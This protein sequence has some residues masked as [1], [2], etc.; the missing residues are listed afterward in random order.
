MTVS[1]A[2]VEQAPSP[3]A[4]IGRLARQIVDAICQ[5][6]AIPRKEQTRQLALLEQALSMMQDA[7]QRIATLEDHI[8]H[9]E[10]LSRTDFLTGI[11]NR[12]GFHDRL[13]S[14]LSGADRHGDTGVVV[15]IDLDHF[16][17]INDRH[18]HEAGDAVLRQVA[19]TLRGNV[20]AGD[21]VARLGGDEFAVVLTH[22][23][24]AEGMYRA[25]RLLA[26]L[27]QAT[28]DYGNH[29]FRIEAS[30][31]AANYSAESD[32]KDLLHRADIAMYRQKRSKGLRYT[33][34]A[35]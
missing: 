27:D 14:V 28:V 26:M 7:G 34:L 16:K 5:N 21:F 9:L 1:A 22:T 31:G 6:S 8:D 3:G 35:G 4:G 23:G 18:G 11:A 25:R 13:R 33:R 17:D 12:R 32:A 20:R 2:V 15:L 10:S 29:C 24:P 19:D 30:V